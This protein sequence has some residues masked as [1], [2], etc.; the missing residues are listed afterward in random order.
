[1]AKEA[2][3][4][5]AAMIE[6]GDIDGVRDFLAQETPGGAFADAIDWLGEDDDSGRTPLIKA[7]MKA[8][9][10]GGRYTE[11]VKELLKPRVLYGKQ[12]SA[13]IAAAVNQ[14]DKAG[15]TVLDY[16]AGVYD[17]NHEEISNL[18]IGAGGVGS[19]G[20]ALF[21]HLKSEKQ[22]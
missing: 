4:V 20:V 12:R 1:M 5:L 14:T 7:V 11:I 22:P 6:K 10:F 13:G 16:V 15:R 18:I 17:A 2:D 19:A 9:V 21:E 3:S 8:K